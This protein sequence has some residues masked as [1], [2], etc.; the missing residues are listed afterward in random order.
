MNNKITKS[1]GML[2]SRLEA[3][4]DGIFAFAMTLLVLS[5]NLPEGGKNADIGAYLLNQLPNFLNFV[6]SFLILAFIWLNLNQEFHHIKRTNY[7]L[8]LL[9]I[10]MLLF[11]VLLP[12]S[13]SLLNDFPDA[14][15]AEM[16]FNINMLL[17][18]C[19]LSSNWWYARK[20]NLIETMG[21]DEHLAMVSRKQY[22]FP[23]ISLLAVALTFFTPGWSSLSYILIPILMYLPSKR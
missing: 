12:F 18:A 23:A 2:P 3:L 10:A 21:D 1:T 14:F 17:L 7:G 13:T 15:A 8:I 19:L 9:N 20:H 11:V 22:V 4:G 16:F 5:I 6:L